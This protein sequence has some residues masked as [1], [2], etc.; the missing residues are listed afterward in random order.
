MNDPVVDRR[1][2]REHLDKRKKYYAAVNGGVSTGAIA[3]EII[4]LLAERYG[5]KVCDS[6]FA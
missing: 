2:I 1:A 3:D 5:I 4:T 6:D